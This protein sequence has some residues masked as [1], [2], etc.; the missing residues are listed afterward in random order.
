SLAIARLHLQPGAVRIT[1][2]AAAAPPVIPTIPPLRL[3]CDHRPRRRADYRAGNG[4]T[5]APPNRTTDYAAERTA[6]D[7]AADRIL[8]R[9]MLRRHNCR[10]TQ[11]HR[12]SQHS[13]HGPSPSGST[14]SSSDEI[15]SSL[16]LLHHRT[17]RGRSSTGILRK[18]G[19]W[20]CKP[21]PDDLRYGGGWRRVG[22]AN[23]AP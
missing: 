5:C 23:A 4:A 11:Q 20:R 19:Q 18:W 10:H 6:D 14:T 1:V 2:V 17:A 13:L 3:G 22:V 21:P 9:R 16:N 8:R 15:K 7:G 12:G